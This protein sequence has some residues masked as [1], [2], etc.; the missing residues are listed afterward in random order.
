MSRVMNIYQYVVGCFPNRI[1][2]NRTDRGQVQNCTGPQIE[3]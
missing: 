2:G 1:D 3:A